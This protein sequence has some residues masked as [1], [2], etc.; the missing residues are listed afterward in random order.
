MNVLSEAA[1]QTAILLSFQGPS[2]L[3]TTVKDRKIVFVTDIK[4]T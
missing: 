2:V 3:K 1:M 4:K